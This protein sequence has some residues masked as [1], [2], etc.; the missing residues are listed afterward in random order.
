[1][2]LPLSDSASKEPRHADASPT[3]EAASS[4][5]EVVSSAAAYCRKVRARAQ[6]D[7]A[8]LSMP[9]VGLRALRFPFGTLADEGLPWNED[10]SAQLRAF[11]SVSPIDIY[12]GA[13]IRS[14]ADLDCVRYATEQG[15]AY[16]LAHGDQHVHAVALR[17]KAAFLEQRTREADSYVAAAKE[18]IQKGIITLSAFNEVLAAHEALVR[19]LLTAKS[20]VRQQ[21]VRNVTPPRLDIEQ[22]RRDFVRASM[23]LERQLSHIRSLDSWRVDLRGGILARDGVD[24]FAMAE[25]SYSLGGPSHTSNEDR[26]LQ[27]RTDELQQAP[28][29]LAYES[30]I[31]TKQTQEKV[32]AAKSQIELLQRRLHVL[33]DAHNALSSSDA[34]RASHYAALFALRKTALEAEIV[35]LESLS[36]TFHEF[37]LK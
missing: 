7:A 3:I 27:A 10:R 17:E 35:Y 33:Q 32:D 16:F 9:K 19:A 13:Q 2:T 36:T 30:S 37:Y 20:A 15:I 11:L 4:E 18:R 12:R 22:S 29:Q 21:Q 31:A 5:P 1:M 14:A 28:G 25:I 23:Q 26:Y 8:L 24:Y 6:A 34:P